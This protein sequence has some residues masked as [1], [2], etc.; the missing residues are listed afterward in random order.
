MF[1]FSPSGRFEWHSLPLPATFA[2]HHFPEK[3]FIKRSPTLGAFSHPHILHLTHVRF[4]DYRRSR[5]AVDPANPSGTGVP[6]VRPRNGEPESECWILWRVE[7]ARRCS[8]SPIQFSAS[9]GGKGEILGAVRCQSAISF[10]FPLCNAL[11]LSAN[12]YVGTV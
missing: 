9:F 10:L 3:T 4:A 7:D 8:R 12:A 5:E 1:P 11:Q 6:G 2:F